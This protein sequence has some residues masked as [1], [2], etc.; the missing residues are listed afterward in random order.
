MTLLSC[1]GS[2]DEEAVVDCCTVA[3]CSCIL[4]LVFV[5][6][7]VVVDMVAFEFIIGLAY[8]NLIQNNEFERWSAEG[9]GCI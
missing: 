7:L 6:A 5:P 2:W 1:S 8:L 3:L 4:E 9:N